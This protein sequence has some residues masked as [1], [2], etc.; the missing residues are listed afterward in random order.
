MILSKNI[1][2]IVNPIAGM[3][4]KVGLKGTDGLEIATKALELGAAPESPQKS[5]S[6]LELLAPIKDKVKILTCS[7]DMGEKAAR[8]CGFDTEV[9]LKSGVTSTPEDTESAARKMLELD[10]SLLMFAGGD[11]TARNIC[12]AIQTK[13]PVIG[14]PTG[15]KIHSAVYATNPKNA[16]RTARLFL[17]GK[18]TS[19]K[20]LEV[21]DIDEAA[22]REGRVTAN[23]YGFL[24]VPFEKRLIQSLKTGGVAGEHTTLQGIA[25]YIIAN[26]EEDTYFIVGPGTTT[27]TLMSRLFLKKELLG[28]D[29]ILN[30]K[31]V[32]GDVNEK[33]IL[34]FI[35]NN[36]AKIIVT[37]I[38]GQGYIFGRGNQQISAEVIKR[39]GKKNIIVIATKSK[40]I[41]LQGKPLFVDTGDETVNKMLSGYVRVV[42]GYRQEMIYKVDC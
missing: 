1:G 29:L 30:K 7:G 37:V 2:L 4:G 16:G 12:N 36:K 24:K 19:F 22:I 42:T 31:L 38:G 14:I 8:I 10:V 5:I 26:M 35:E 32:S 18:I 41:A 33:T 34:S 17:E 40:L 28:V 3:G 25:E 9:V 13:V 20:E 23:L 15:V 21:M 39:V 11:G 6:A 27:K